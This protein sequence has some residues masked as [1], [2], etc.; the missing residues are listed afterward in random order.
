MYLTLAVLF[1][2]LSPGVLLTLPPVGR[3]IFMSGK[4]SL[5]AAA[6]HAVVFWLVLKYLNS[7]GVFEGFQYLQFTNV[8]KPCDDTKPPCKHGTTCFNGICKAN[9]RVQ[10]DCNPT[11]PPCAA[12]LFCSNGK[13]KFAQKVRENCNPPDLPCATGLICSNGKCR[14]NYQ[15]LGETCNST[16]PPC[17]SGLTC[18]DNICKELN[19]GLDGKCN[20]TTRLCSSGLECVT[21]GRNGRF[22]ISGTMDGFCKKPFAY[23]A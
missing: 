22:R 18:S 17:K 16:E 3:K 23:V 5:V 13:C 19:V 7:C 15:M 4:T 20:L 10:E 9:K 11:E 6:V 12:A 14:V 21:I 1:F 8:N 2:V